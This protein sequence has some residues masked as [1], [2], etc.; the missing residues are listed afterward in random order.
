M[1]YPNQ[2]SNSFIEYI[3]STV[4]PTYELSKAEALK[5]AAKM[6]AS[7]SFRGIQQFGARVLG[8]DEATEELK[9]KDRTLQQILDNEEYGSQAMAAF[10]GSAVVADPLGYVPI[11][12][13]ISKGKKAKNLWELTKYGG[14]AGGFHAGMGYVS[15]E[16]PGLVGEKQSRLENIAIGATAG[17]ALGALGGAA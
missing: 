15:E 16:S 4:D 6:G 3:R 13:W 11:A 10:L 5:Y 1:A 17:S 7:D 2:D 14:M 9:K 12:G 8:M